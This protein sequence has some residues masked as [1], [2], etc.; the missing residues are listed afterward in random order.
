[1]KFVLQH[2]PGTI[3]LKNAKPKF[4]E[5]VRRN[6]DLRKNIPQNSVFPVL[7]EQGIFIPF[8]AFSIRV[9]GERPNTGGVLFPFVLN[10]VSKKEIGS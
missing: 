10:E 6:P 9:L 3:V 7:R 4:E 5:E 1:M 8:N 2:E